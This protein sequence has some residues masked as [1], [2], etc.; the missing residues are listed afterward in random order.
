MSWG[1]S[2]KVPHDKT[3]GVSRYHWEPGGLAGGVQ[4]GSEEL[5]FSNVRAAGRRLRLEA[6]TEAVATSDGARAAL[7]VT[8]LG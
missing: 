5:S 7:Q 6:R 1:T 3:R 8:A 4:A 2:D